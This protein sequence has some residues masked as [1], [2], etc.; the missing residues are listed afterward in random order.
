MPGKIKNGK[1]SETKR[2]KVEKS[3]KKRQGRKKTSNAI[4]GALGEKLALQAT[5]LHTKIITVADEIA[6]VHADVVEFMD[7][8]DVMARRSAGC[9]QPAV[10]YRRMPDGSWLECYLQSDCTYGGCKPISADQVPN[11]NLVIDRRS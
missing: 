2:T 8:T 9:N 5:E 10:K 1:P 7:T 4:P 11:A 6:S 3:V